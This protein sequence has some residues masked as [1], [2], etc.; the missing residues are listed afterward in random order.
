[1]EHPDRILIGGLPTKEGLEAVQQLAD[2]YRRWVPEDKVITT[3]LWSAELAKLASNAFLAQRIS[4]I[5][6]LSALCEATGADVMELKR[7][8]GSDKRIG[9]YFLNASVGFGGSCFGKDLIGLIY[10]CESF[11]LQE[12]AEYWRQV[13]HDSQ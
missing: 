9:P 11:N 3:G 10:L 6:S 8:L 7:V 1:M 5:N 13:I 4:S 2:I 12:V